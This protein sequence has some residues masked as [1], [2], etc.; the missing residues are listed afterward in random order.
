MAESAGKKQIPRRLKPSRNDKGESGSGGFYMAVSIVLAE[1]TGLREDAVRKPRRPNPKR[2]GELAEAAFLLKAQSMGFRVARPWGDSDRYDFILDSGGRLWRVQLKSTEVL[3]SRGYEVQ[4]VVSVYNRGE[5]RSKV[6]YTAEEID[7]L[8]VHI[9]PRDVWY[10]LP[11]AAL[12]SLRN[13]RF[14]PDIKSK[15]ARWESYREAWWVM[16]E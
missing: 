14:Y 3:H 6:G 16:R 5:A 2:R 15:S 8:V 13:L 10:V 9:G 7:V 12:A 1:L 4:P 11:V